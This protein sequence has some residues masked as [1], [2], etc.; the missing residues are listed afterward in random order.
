MDPYHKSR[1]RKF[2]VLYILFGSW[3]GV[4]SPRLVD[5]RLRACSSS[6]GQDA[7][8]LAKGNPTYQFQAKHDAIAAE[9]SICLELGI[10]VLKGAVN[11]VDAAISTTLAH[12]AWG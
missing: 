10:D 8:W 4:I 6:P 11:A 7:T 3:T 5:S 1:E 12:P 2:T 9:N